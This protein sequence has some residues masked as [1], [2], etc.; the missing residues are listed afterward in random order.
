[1]FRDVVS[2]DDLSDQE[3]EN[4]FDIAD[5]FLS[6]MATPE[7][8]YRIQGR[9][10]VAED[11]ILATLFY[12]PSTR[13]RMSF[14]SAML[15]LGGRVISSADARATSTAK[16]ETIADTVR[17]TQNYADVIVIRHP[18][19]G[20][21]QVAADYADIPVINAGDGA[22]EHPTQTL[23]DLYTLRTAQQPRRGRT[24]RESLKDLTVVLS[25]DLRHGRT[26]H[27]L[28]YAL[29]R[30]GA[31]IV[32]LPAAENYSFPDHVRHRLETDYGCIPVAVDEVLGESLPADV[33]YVTPEKPHQLSLITSDVAEV[34]IKLSLKE[35]KALRS[36]KGVDFF[37]ATRL[38]AERK[39]ADEAEID[40]PVVNAEF[41]K[42]KPY[43]HS[44]VMHPLPRV[45]EL[46]YDLDDDSRGVYFRQA[47][48]G[49]PVRM[50]LIA[51]LLE[52]RPGLGGPLREKYPIYNRAD[53]LSC[54]NL[55]CVTR[56]SSEQRYL[57]PQF[58][59]IGQERPVVRCMYCDHEQEPHII[60]NARS[61]KY[62]KETS[63][64]KSIKIDDLVLFSDER[65]A[66]QAGHQPV[67]TDAPVSASHA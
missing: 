34:S 48:Y 30:F 3:I 49:V 61:R 42:K 25:G 23:C 11:F 6:D 31:R 13:T 36:I 56:Q 14:E 67:K 55:Q 38:Q 64:W 57:T 16:G 12:E 39:D 22:H 28:A 62:R 45:N 8:P 44:Q 65:D 24:T 41:L 46:S 19:E 32:P 59:I 1:M 53:T 63:A 26:V 20:A 17:V 5:A 47:A 51:A 18:W 10:S 52:L 21:A 15:R 29:A 50:A 60:S 58:R 40:Y 37:Y 4:V 27:S 35:Q 9:A 7:K 54:P 66:E 43:K 2:I 33:L